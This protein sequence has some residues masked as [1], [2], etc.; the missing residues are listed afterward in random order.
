M[1]ICL[2]LD[3]FFFITSEKFTVTCIVIFSFDNTVFLSWLFSI[4]SLEFVCLFS[5]HL[6]EKVFISSLLSRELLPAVRQLFSSDFL[7]YVE[8]DVYV[9]TF[10]CVDFVAWARIIRLFF[11]VALGVKPTV[12]FRATFPVSLNEFLPAE[13]TRVTDNTRVGTNHVTCYLQEYMRAGKCETVV[14]E[15]I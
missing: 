10:F 3:F 5:T 7:L 12:Y 4:L 15:E 8:I 9:E 14:Q 2:L 13:E 6:L 1:V 11:F